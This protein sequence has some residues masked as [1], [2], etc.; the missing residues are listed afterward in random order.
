MGAKIDNSYFE[1]G[2]G[3]KLDFRI[4]WGYQYLYLSGLSVP[5]IKRFNHQLP[6]AKK[7][8]DDVG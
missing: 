2:N 4:D 7:Y 6:F 5:G 3:V 1:G 8:V